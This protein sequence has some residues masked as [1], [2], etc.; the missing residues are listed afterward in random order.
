MEQFILS[1]D[2]STQ[3]TK[4]MLFDAAGRLTARADRPHRQ[5]INEKGWVSHDLEEIYANVLVVCREVAEKA[6]IDPAQ[7][8][9]MGISN[10]R[11]TVAAWDRADG[12]P[13]GDRK[14][15]V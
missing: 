8:A 6:G 11:E 1:V 15:V 12:T 3:G 13:V 7:I 5:Y 2:Q 10:Q 4:A 9:A 14:S